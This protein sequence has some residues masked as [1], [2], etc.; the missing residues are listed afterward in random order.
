MS[1]NK[2]TSDSMIV[3]GPSELS[4]ESPM[5]VLNAKF[6]VGRIP[7][8]ATVILNYSDY[9]ISNTDAYLLVS[10]QVM[11]L[12]C[13][14]PRLKYAY[15]RTPVVRILV[16]R[17]PVFTG[18]IFFDKNFVRYPTVAYS[19][20]RLYPI[21]WDRHFHS[22]HPKFDIK[23]DDSLEFDHSDQKSVRYIRNLIYPYPLYPRF[24]V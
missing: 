1:V 4:M 13:S 7:C 17:D 9:H 3:H 21:T 24:T 8:Q 22:I 11:R 19:E 18:V 16:L 5:Y 23:D 2:W 14:I 10:Q 6:K 12:L 15:S 20:P